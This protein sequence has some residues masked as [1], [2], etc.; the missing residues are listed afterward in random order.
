MT[1]EFSRLL[2]IREVLGA[3]LPGTA[4]IDVGVSDMDDAAVI[5]LGDGISVA[6]AS[7]FVRGSEFYLFAM[8]L[9]N[10]YDVGYYLIAANLSDMAAMGACPIALTTVVRYSDMMSDA[11][12]R[13]VFSGMRAA[14]DKYTT[15]IVGGDTGGYVSDVF[16]ATALGTLP[17][18]RA[19]LRSGAQIGDVVCVTGLIGRAITAL[20]Y[21]KEAKPKGF[22]LSREEEDML[23]DS[24]KRPNARVAEGMLLSLA[25]AATSCQDVSDGLRA[26]VDQMAIAS[27]VGIK[28]YEAQLPIS[29][30]SEVVAAAVGTDLSQL[31]MSASV[32][33]ELL[34][35]VPAM[36]YV[37]LREKFEQQGLDFTVIGEVIAGSQNCIVRRNGEITS[38]PGVPW[39]HQSKSIVTD[40][41][42]K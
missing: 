38:I 3:K 10:Y 6:M 18:G 20:V 30:I 1:D 35:T 16:A 11:D 37:A 22:L 7:D 14:A 21:F 36:E 42:R 26:T 19:I 28:L 29:P 8:G 25:G 24:W 31:V 2:I 5:R 9:M 12:F 15:P 39:K 33:F 34:F 41:L 23:L 40:V 4:I 32:D 17:N 27:N 13:D